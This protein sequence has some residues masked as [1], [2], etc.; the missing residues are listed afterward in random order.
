[1]SS[2]YFVFWIL[3]SPGLSHLAAPQHWRSNFCVKSEKKI[4]GTFGI[5]RIT[6][7][8]TPGNLSQLG[9]EQKGHKDT[10]LLLQEDFMA[11]LL[12]QAQI[13]QVLK[14]FSEGARI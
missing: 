8:F 10:F 12:L 3:L 13:E 4:Q 2:F 5:I 11:F 1:M 6:Q 9:Y 14:R 7:T